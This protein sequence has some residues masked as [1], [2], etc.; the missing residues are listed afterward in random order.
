MSSLADFA[1]REGDK[2]GAIEWSRKAYEA[3]QGPATRVQWAI[4]WS[5]AVL[6]NAPE[7]EA[8]VTKAAEAVIAELG[9]SPDSYYQ[10]TRVKVADWGDKLLEWSAAHDGGE[11]LARL[12][13]KMAEVCARQGSQA[14]TCGNWAK[15]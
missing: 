11:A 10:R 14:A 1:E 3:S 9:K 5:N 13:S 6:R 8:T 12:R 15:A 2:A 4:L 7:D